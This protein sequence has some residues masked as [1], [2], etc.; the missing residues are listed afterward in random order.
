MRKENRGERGNVCGVWWVLFMCTSYIII[1]RKIHYIFLNDNI[2]AYRIYHISYFVS[3][4]KYNNTF[5]HNGSLFNRSTSINNRSICII[6][7]AFCD[8]D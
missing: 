6:L 3:Y 5:V 4:Q 7:L 2:Y 1:I 8:I